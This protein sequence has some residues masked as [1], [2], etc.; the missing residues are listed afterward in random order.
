MRSGSV[1]P[2]QPDILD[3]LFELRTP[4]QLFEK[5]K[6]DSEK[7]RREPTDE[8]LF[9]WLCTL[10]HLRDWICPGGPKSYKHKPPGTLTAEERLHSELHTDNNFGI[11][12]DLCNNAK[13]FS[14]KGIG[15]RSKVKRGFFIGFNQ[16]GDHFNERNLLVDGQDIRVIAGTV[17]KRFCAYF[18]SKKEA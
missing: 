4:R 18:K 5:A 14:D 16:P 17:L 1:M 8:N 15:T 2:T 12:R 3:G 11:I 6:R 7:F 9:N 10:N 13:H